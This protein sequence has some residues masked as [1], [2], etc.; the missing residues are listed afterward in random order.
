MSNDAMVSVLGFT[1]VPGAVGWPYMVVPYDGRSVGFQHCA[2]E[3]HPTWLSVYG[4]TDHHSKLK[5]LLG[6]HCNGTTGQKTRLEL[7]SRKEIHNTLE[8]IGGHWI[9]RAERP[10]LSTSC[11]V[12]YKFNAHFRAGLRLIRKFRTSIL[13]NQIRLLVHF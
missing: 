1:G 2:A 5:C 13:K 8:E 9:K 4:R 11:R 12:N 7:R 6:A 3:E 10:H